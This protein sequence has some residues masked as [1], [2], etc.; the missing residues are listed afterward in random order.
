MIYPRLTHSLVLACQGFHDVAS[1]LLLVAGQDTAMVCAILD[2][3]ARWY[4]RDAMAPDFS[5]LAA[6]L[7]VVFPLVREA[8]SDPSQQ[9]SSSSSTSSPG[10]GGG[11]SG[12]RTFEALEMSGVQPIIALPWVITWFAHDV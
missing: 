4:V 9:S 5:T 6:C 10:D 7:Q 2:R 3:V 1:V 8:H 12:P 11:V